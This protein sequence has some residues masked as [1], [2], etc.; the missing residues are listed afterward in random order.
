MSPY[1]RSGLMAVGIAAAVGLVVTGFL[2]AES[3]ETELPGAV[4]RIVPA[5]GALISPQGD[6]GAD[7]ADDH[8]GVLFVDGHEIPLDQLTVV[9]PLG[10]I[11]FSPGPGRDLASFE[12]GTHTVSVVYWRR[13]QTRDDASTFTWEFRVG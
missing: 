11:F 3:G 2:V 9:E 12:A 6:V 8:T 7:L 4:E 10:Q 5:D 1:V 13:Q